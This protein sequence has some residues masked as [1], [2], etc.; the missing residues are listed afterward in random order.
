M[1]K[2][3]NNLRAKLNEVLS[4]DMTIKTIT[5]K[6]KLIKGFKIGLCG[7]VIAS[8]VGVIGYQAYSMN[9]MENEITETSLYLNTLEADVYLLEN[10]NS[11]EAKDNKAEIDSQVENLWTTTTTETTHE[12]GTTTTTREEKEGK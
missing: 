10:P 3:I 1:K 11:Q 4:H 6:S 7:L 12:D 5:R 8:M 9:Y 2:F